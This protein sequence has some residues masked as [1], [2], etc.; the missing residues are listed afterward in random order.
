MKNLRLVGAL[1]G[2]VLS[3]S[4]RLNAESTV[5]TGAAVSGQ[6][7]ARNYIIWGSGLGHRGSSEVSYWRRIWDSSGLG[8]TVEMAGSGDDRRGNVYSSPLLTYFRQY[9]MKLGDGRMGW[10]VSTGP[11][12]VHFVGDRR[13]DMDSRG[14]GGTVE[15]KFF[16]SFPLYRSIAGDPEKWWQKLLDTS[17]YASW[18]LRAT[19]VRLEGDSDADPA[20]DCPYGDPE[21]WGDRRHWDGNARFW[22]GSGSNLSAGLSWGF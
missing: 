10:A 12:F 8:V 3:V 11:T 1:L 16:V 7:A 6:E 14:V 19:Y 2:A 13:G 17:L 5:F 18:G 20:V 22:A 4:G 21:P 15:G 9:P